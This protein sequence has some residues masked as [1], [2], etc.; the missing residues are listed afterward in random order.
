MEYKKTD[1]EK[2]LEERAKLDDIIQSHYRKWIAVMFTDIVGSTSFFES[3]GDIDGRSMLHRH[4]GVVLP[5]IKEHKGTLLKTIG[6]ATMSMYEDPADALRAAVRIQYDIRS[7]NEGKA[8]KEQLHVR[9][10]VNFGEGL[11][12]AGDVFGDCVNVASR[13]V[14]L[15]PAD[16]IYVTDKVYSAVRNNDEFIFRF[17]KTAEVKGKKD[18]ITVFRLLWHDEELCLGKLRGIAGP[19]QRRE[20]IFIIEASLSGKKLKISG[21]EKAEGEERTVKSYEETGFHADLIKSYI[22][23]IIDLLNRANRRGCIGNDLLIKLREYGG[24]LFDELIPVRVKERLAAVKD[25]HLLISIDDN[26]VHI[27]WELLFDGSDFFC[28]KFSMGRTVSTRQ[29]VSPLA[30]SVGRPLKIQVLADP[31]GD[32]SAAYEEGMLITSEIGRIDEWSDVSLRTTDIRTDYVQSKMRRFDIVH[33]AGHA[34]HDAKKPEESGW[35]LKEGKLS[36]GQIRKMAGATPMPSLVFSNACQSG[37]TGEWHLGEDYEERIFG[38][39]NAFLLSGVQHYIGTFW[40]IPDEAGAHFAVTFY[41]SLIQGSAIGEA[42]RASRQ[43]LIEKYGEDMII[44]ASYMLYGDP[45]V[46]YVEQTAGTQPDETYSEIAEEYVPQG[47]RSR[48]E[49]EISFAAPKEGKQKSLIA[50]GVVGLLLVV[51]LTIAALRWNGKELSFTTNPQPAVPV[52]GAGDSAGAKRT[53]ELVASLAERY[54]DG[55][56]D[57]ANASQDDWSTKPLTMVVLEVKSSSDSS[58]GQAEKNREKLTNLLGQLL[59]TNDRIRLVERELLDNLLE[60]L[61]LS[62]SSLADPATSLKLGKVLSA[63]II[64]TGSI[65][66]DKS[67]QTVTL[68]MIDTETTAVRKVIS[69][70]SKSAD[71]DKEIAKDLAAKIVDWAKMDF[72]VQG[73][74][75]SVAGNIAKLNLGQI[76]GLKKGDKLEVISEVKKGSGL[77]ASVAELEIT[78]VAKDSSQAVA[79]GKADAVKKDAKVRVRQ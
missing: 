15:C 42:L 5:V 30:R 37:Q 45:S 12:E 27:P 1:I 79:A 54:R 19:P 73:R 78:E 69:A 25:R 48:Q 35:L 46:R 2:I 64:I 14:S 47:L 41:K 70:E 10:G 38:L 26:L 72:P 59:Q 58:A 20:G 62:S 71:I 50:A 51:V 13:V 77:Y 17:A 39:A 22:K 55:K 33:Y 75:V 24:L 18:P 53:D 44:W 60:E 61:K 66:Q 56:F 9:V 3:R 29:S 68:R 31:R 32:L 76:H 8:E 6:D 63:N 57:Q 4:N 74:V 36:A 65:M 52:T 43:S 11:V 49:A 21:Y 67:G 7:Y 23:G 34:D 16:E 40:E 28:R